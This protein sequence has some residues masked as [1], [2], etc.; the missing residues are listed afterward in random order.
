MTNEL[1]L[2][3]WTDLSEI[4]RE[5]R[6]WQKLQVIQFWGDPEIFS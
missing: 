2:P 6:E 3:A 1:A 4:F 5:C